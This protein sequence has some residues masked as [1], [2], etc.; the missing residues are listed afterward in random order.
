[1]AKLRP[2]IYAKDLTII[3]C[4]SGLLK[5]IPKFQKIPQDNPQ[6]NPNK[7]HCVLNNVPIDVLLLPQVKQTNK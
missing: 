1:M 3:Y 7:R 2:D 6:Y 5:R 4:I